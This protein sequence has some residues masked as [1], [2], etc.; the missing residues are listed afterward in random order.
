MCWLCVL[1]SVSVLTGFRELRYF[2]SASRSSSLSHT[3][4]VHKSCCS[5]ICVVWC[6]LCA[7]CTFVHFKGGRGRGR[8]ARRTIGYLPNWN[9]VLSAYIVAYSARIYWHSVWYS[10]FLFCGRVVKYRVTHT[11][12]FSDAEKRPNAI[13]VLSSVFQRRANGVAQ[14]S[15]M[16]TGINR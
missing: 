15:D 14:L 2:L 16:T 4:S 6:M 13:L 11:N 8:N 3:D 5:H 9:C 7:V 10:S 1:E 12:S